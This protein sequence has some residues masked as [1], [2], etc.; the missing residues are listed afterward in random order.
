MIDPK[1]MPTNGSDSG[2]AAVRAMIS[3]KAAMAGFLLKLPSGTR[4]A[5]TI[6]IPKL[7][8]SKKAVPMP[9]IMRKPFCP[10]FKKLCCEIF[11]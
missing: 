9:D 4:K 2:T 5:R 1:I 10:N 7:P 3:V 8:S 6:K 11:V